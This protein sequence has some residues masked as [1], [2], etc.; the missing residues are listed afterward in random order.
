MMRIECPCCGTRDEQEFYFGGESHVSRPTLEADDLEWS[1]YLFNR[2][3]P[4]GIHF[5]QWL[6][7]YGC[8]RWF[9]IAR[10][11]VTH[12]IYAVYPM[13][14]PKPELPEIEF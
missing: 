7:R 6:H 11:T 12:E 9:N 5:E 4:K 8:G 3:N 1:D 10:D 2:E 13:G 14:K